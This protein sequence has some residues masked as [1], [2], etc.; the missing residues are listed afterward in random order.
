MRK[1]FLTRFLIAALWSG[2]AYAQGIQN[3]DI[4]ISAG[5]VW[6]RSNVIPGTNVTLAGST[7]HSIE[8]DYGYQFERMSAAS[9]MA[10]VWSTFAFPGAWKA[11]LPVSGGNSSSW[12]AFALGLRLMVPVKPRLSFYAVSDGGFTAFSIPFVT[13]G[14]NPTVTS[15]G[16]TSH[17]A[18]I[19]GGGADLRLSRWFSLRAEVRDLVTGRELSGA[20]RNHPLPVFGVAIHF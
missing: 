1:S 3:Y 18:F 12:G 11:E 20:G 16:D 4:F 9:L 6:T 10:D 14:A 19:F 15:T 8:I 5:P 2:A 13:E 7:G 17:G